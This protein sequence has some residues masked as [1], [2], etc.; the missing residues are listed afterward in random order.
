MGVVDKEARVAREGFAN[1]GFACM[2]RE[3][4]PKL[5]DMHSVLDMHC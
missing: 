1:S 2:Q 3:G 4:V 5:G